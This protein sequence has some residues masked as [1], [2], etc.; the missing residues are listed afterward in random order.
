MSKKIVAAILCLLML[1]AFVGCGTPTDESDDAQTQA[2]GND[3]SSSSDTNDSDEPTDSPQEVADPFG[4]YDETIELTAVR[5]LQDGIEFVEGESL[6]NNV[7]SRAYEDMLGI[8]LSYEWTTPQAQYAQKLNVSTASSTSLPDLMWVDAAQLKRMVEDGQLADLT[9]VYSSYAAD[10]TDKVLHDDGGSAM[11]AATFGGKLYGLPHIQSGYGSTEV[12]WV[13]QDW[14][15]NLNLDVPETMQDV[16]AIARTFA[17]SDPDQN[18]AD[19]TFGFGVNK[20]LV[21]QNN[22]PYAVLDGFFNAYHAYPTIWVKDDEGKLVYGGIQPEM[23][24]ALAELQKLYSE[25]VLDPEFGVKDAF[26]I[27]EEANGGKIGMFYGYFWNCASGWLQDGK[28]A[29]PDLEWVA[30]PI[31]SID[32]TTA[33]AMAPFATTYYTVVSKDC[34][35]PEAAVKMYNLVLEK[36]FGETGEPEIYNATADNIAAFN[37]AY[38]Y[39]EPP[40]KNL[41]AQMMVAEAL[42]SGDTSQLNAEQMNYFNTCQAFIDT[43]DLEQWGGYNMFGPTGGLAVIN[44]YVKDGRVITDQY[45]GAPTDGMAEYNATLQKLQLEA[46]TKIITGNASIDEFDKFVTDWLNLGGQQITDEVNDWLAS[47]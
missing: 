9:D 19:D 28:V 40:M 15:D 44:E 42:E 6:E 14:L 37:Y 41:D 21:A 17:T 20:G 13:R 2:G 29:N 18:G 38:S 23:K 12:L 26:K 30:V 43:G 16:L 11:E 32:G 31:T 22:L 36:M 33:S 47:K 4:K 35:Y 5:Y 45:F 24:D 46:F 25:G 1:F 8:K 39:G 7:W 34:E 10:Y 3:S 27:S